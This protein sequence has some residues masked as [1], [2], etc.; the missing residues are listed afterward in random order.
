M[1]QSFHHT[2][3]W[4]DGRI[5]HVRGHQ[6]RHLCGRRAADHSAA[7]P[8]L[9]VRALDSGPQ[10]SPHRL[11]GG[12]RGVRRRHHAD[13]AHLAGRGLP[14]AHHPAGLR[15]GQAPRRG[16]P[17]VPRLRHAQIRPRPLEHP[18]TPPPPPRPSPPSPRPAPTRPPP[19]PPPP[20]LTPPTPSPPTPPL[21]PRPSPW[22]TRPPQPSPTRPPAS[23]SQTQP[24][25][26]LRRPP[27]PPT[28]PSPSPQPPRIPPPPLRLPPPP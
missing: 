14:A 16:L 19:S 8:Q 25:P 26:R 6:L 10:G 18:P 5:R 4:C 1:S 15:R 20:P 7:R 27:P 3:G 28:R 22:P 9:D 11:P 2:S 23:P 13:R 24:P 17:A 21:P 12:D